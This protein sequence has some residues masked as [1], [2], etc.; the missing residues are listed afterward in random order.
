MLNLFRLGVFLLIAF[1]LFVPRQAYSAGVVLPG[2]TELADRGTWS[3]PALWWLEGDFTSPEGEPFL[4]GKRGYDYNYLTVDNNYNFTASDD[5]WVGYTGSQ[6]NRLDIHAGSKV[7]AKGSV[8]VGQGN[9]MYFGR[10]NQ[11]TVSGAGAVLS[12]DDHIR[13]GY[14]TS[15]TSSDNTLSLLDGGIAIV[16]SNKDGVGEL[17]LGYHW[18]YGNTWLELRNGALFMYGDKRQEFVDKEILTSIKVWDDASNEFKRVA[19]YDGTTWVTTEYIDLL[20]IDYIDSPAVA[21]D[22][23][24]SEDFVGFTVLHDVRPV[25]VP[26]AIV[27]LGAGLGA[28]GVS[29]RFRPSK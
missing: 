20:G 1:S 11:L 18:A 7:E 8:Y 13:I 28:L 21:Q 27:L 15:W 5:L 26:S 19:E 17:Y 29:R 25:P 12:A 16:D 10:E 4:I 2:T 22:L 3:S 6:H 23:G 24:F 9:I 14:G